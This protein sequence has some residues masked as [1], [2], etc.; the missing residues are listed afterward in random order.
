MTDRDLTGFVM[1]TVA[2][3]RPLTAG[4]MQQGL[5]EFYGIAGMSLT[6]LGRCNT[7]VVYSLM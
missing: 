5:I 3:D 6:A 2:F 1:A 4:L 7:S